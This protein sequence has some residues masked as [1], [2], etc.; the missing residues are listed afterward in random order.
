MSVPIAGPRG[1]LSIAATFLI[2]LSGKLLP[3]QLVY[4]GKTK[5]LIPRFKFLELFSVSENP[6]HF[7]NKAEP[8]KIIEEIILLDV[9][10]QL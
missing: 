9:K 2:T 8:F 10:Q 6:R 7:S 5:Q 1:K 4:G 3:I